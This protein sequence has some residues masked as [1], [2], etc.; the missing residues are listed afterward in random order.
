MTAARVA[1]VAALLA[2]AVLAQDPPAVAPKA[3][4]AAVAELGTPAAGKRAGR[5]A[6]ELGGWSLPGSATAEDILHQNC[7]RTVRQI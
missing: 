6:R 2:A 1:V 3:P 5:Q 7:R 4:D